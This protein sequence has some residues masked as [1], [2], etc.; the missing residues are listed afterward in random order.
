LTCIPTAK[1]ALTGFGFAGELQLLLRSPFGENFVLS[2]APTPLSGRIL[3]DPA[4]PASDGG[5]CENNEC[6]GY[7]Q[8]VVGG[9]SANFGG[10]SITADDFIVQ[11][12]NNDLY[13]VDGHEVVFDTIAFVY[14]FDISPLFS[15]QLK[16][17][18]VSQPKAW[19]QL[20]LIGAEDTFDDTVLPQSIDA[21]RY[22][23]YYNI[24]DEDA[25][26]IDLPNGPGFNTPDIFFSATL[27]VIPIPGDYNG[28]RSVTPDD[29]NDWRSTYGSTSDLAADGNGNQ[30]IDAADYVVW[31]D[32]LSAGHQSTAV[33]EPYTLSSITAA[34]LALT[35]AAHRTRRSEV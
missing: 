21:S 11:V 26:R 28:D 8:H 7:R 14:R 25:T 2:P 23:T 13:G 31:R 10:L 34:I 3:Y 29:Y 22:N 1:A 6:L 5:G 27:S 12:K 9:I 19:F 24:L 18:G 30:I 17:N 20:N 4:A 15:S 16:V 32:N 33:P 35:A